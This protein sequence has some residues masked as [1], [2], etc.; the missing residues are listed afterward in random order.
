M[1]TQD[2]IGLAGG[3]NLYAYA[4]NNPIAYND[5]YGL[6]CPRNDTACQLYKGGMQVLGFLAGALDGGARGGAAGLACG[7][8]A[9]VCSPVLATAGAL[10]EGFSAAQA[11]GILAEGAYTLNNDNDS[12]S[13]SGGSQPQYKIPKPGSSGKAGATDAPSWAK[14]QRPLVGE[15]GKNYAKRLLDDK[16][17]AG[18]WKTGA[19]SEFN[20]LQKYAD[21]HF[22]DPPPPAAPPQ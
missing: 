5:P 6:D 2:P 4:G 3:V 15:S 16:Y 19:G 21:R 7:P 10:V 9:E 13:N 1:L 14:G 18:K 17:G 8:L 22:M 20:Q 11:A 12:P